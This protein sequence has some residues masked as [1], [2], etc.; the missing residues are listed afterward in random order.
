MNNCTQLWR[1]AGLEVKSVKT[2]GLEPLLEVE[3]V[4]ESMQLW[5]E[6]RFQ[7]T[8]VKN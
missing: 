4:Q 5:C 1:E 6:A 2:A 3:M 7:V 8:S